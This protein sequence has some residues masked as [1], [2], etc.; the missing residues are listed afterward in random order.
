[1]EEAS[2]ST[3]DNASGSNDDEQYNKDTSRWKM[4]DEEMEALCDVDFPIFDTSS[5]A[6][7]QQQQSQ[8]N[9]DDLSKHHVGKDDGRNSSSTTANNNKPV[10]DKADED[11]IIRCFDLSIKS[12]IDGI[13]AVPVFEPDV[14]PEKNDKESTTT[15]TSISKK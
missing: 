15:T 3:T 14:P 1:M 5:S 4:V 2:S 9:D 6:I 8:S 13:G 10:N 11:A 12:H 7:A